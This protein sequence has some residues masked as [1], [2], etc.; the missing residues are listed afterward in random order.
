M[1][2]GLLTPSIPA[3]QST[4]CV[5]SDVLRGRHI[6]FLTTVEGMGGS[7]VLVADALEGAVRAG[8]QVTCWAVPNGGIREIL[9]ARGL[10]REV[11]IRILTGHGSAAPIT[12]AASPDQSGTPLTTK[13]RSGGLR[14]VVRKLTPRWA[15]CLV[16]FFKDAIRFRREMKVVRPDLVFVHISGDEGSAL[17]ARMALGRRVVGCYHMSLCASRLG[18]VARLA[19]RLRKTTSMWAC[20]QVIHTSQAPRDEWCRN[21][22]YPRS[23][24]HVIYNGVDI[25]TESEPRE[26]VRREL[27]IADR[28][29]VFCIPG[30]LHPAKGHTHLLEAIARAPDLRF[31]TQFLICG[32]GPIRAELE[33]RVANAGLGAVVRFL[34]WR[35]DLPRILAAA[36]CTILPSVE[37]ENFS[38]AVLESL[39]AGTPAIVTRVGGMAEAI[40]DRFN[41][42]V[43]PIGDPDALAD[44]VRQVIRDD[45]LMRELRANARTD[46]EVRFTRSRMMDEYVT[47]FQDIL[48]RA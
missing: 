37:G 38:V 24:T 31:G 47:L 9:T 36:D 45:G 18:L 21:C 15:Q 6:G 4:H 28:E 7:E 26:I 30:R 22:L 14:K 32:D 8:A 5:T 46:A 42:F 10:D 43:V 19:E 39:A 48:T 12:Q 13:G 33:A 16:G 3:V 44:A 41:G 1:S 2:S 25:P 35:T 34:G 29:R 27:G 23:R 40:R 17:G 20:S 11:T